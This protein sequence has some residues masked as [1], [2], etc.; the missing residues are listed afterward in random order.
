MQTHTTPI[1]TG[2]ARHLETFRGWLRAQD[3][4][5]APELEAALSVGGHD[6]ELTLSRAQWVN[7][8]NVLYWFANDVA[9]DKT[10]RQAFDFIAVVEGVLDALPRVLE[11]ET[12]DPAD[13]LA[14][15][16]GEPV[17]QGTFAW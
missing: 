7:L 15:V 3:F 1:G 9:K 10:R 16:V 8:S 5:L 6:G 13:P 12:P 2:D 4:P 17:G 11:P 14:D